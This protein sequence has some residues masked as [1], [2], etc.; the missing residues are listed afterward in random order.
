LYGGEL[1]R[2][3]IARAEPMGGALGWRHLMPITQW[4]A[5]KS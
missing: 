5:V 2:I 3:L 4:S 1:V